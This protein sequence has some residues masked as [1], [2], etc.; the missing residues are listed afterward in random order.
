MNYTQNYNY[1]PNEYRDKLES[2]LLRC[3]I[4]YESPYSSGF[5]ISYFGDEIKK[6]EAKLKKVGRQLKFEFE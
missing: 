6:T 3:K 2:H 1:D 4:N 5:E